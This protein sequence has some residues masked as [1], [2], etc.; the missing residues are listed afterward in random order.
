MK[1]TKITKILVALDYN[2]TAI[3]VA[4]AS[5]SLANSMNAEV[6]LLHVISDPVYYS[7]LAYSPIM[8]L[9]GEMDISPE[10]PVDTEGLKIVSQK[11]LDKL[12]HHLGGESIKTIVG[13]GEIASAILETAKKYHIDIIAMGSHSTKWLESIVMGSVTS[14]VLRKSSVP[15]F[16]VP[17]KKHK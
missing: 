14:D 11:F 13:E 1:T 10:L 6:Y 5:Y 9:T 7:T 12:K 4:E 8:G 15:L 2:Q 16:V 3:K 17:T